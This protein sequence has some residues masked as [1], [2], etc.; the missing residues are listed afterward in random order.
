M[1]NDN[2]KCIYQGLILFFSFFWGRKSY[3]SKSH[4]CKLYVKDLKKKIHTKFI[5]QKI[6]WWIH[7]QT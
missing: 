6:I 1:D 5:T 4:W 2:A 3:S 7:L